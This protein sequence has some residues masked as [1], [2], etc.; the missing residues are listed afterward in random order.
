MTL[1]K[2][3]TRKIQQSQSTQNLNKTC[4][5]TFASNKKNHTIEAIKK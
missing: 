4:K 5:Q 3:I 1:H 2:Q